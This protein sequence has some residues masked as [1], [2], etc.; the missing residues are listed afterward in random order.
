LHGDFLKLRRVRTHQLA[1]RPAIK[2]T[3]TREIIMLVVKDM[4]VEFMF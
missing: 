2:A 3:E 4:V 1:K